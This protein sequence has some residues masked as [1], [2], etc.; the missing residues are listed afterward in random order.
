MVK[1]HARASRSADPAGD[2]PNH[3]QRA[4][5]TRRNTR[6]YYYANPRQRSA[7][8]HSRQHEDL[9]WPDPGAAGRAHARRADG[10]RPP[11]KRKSQALDQDAGTLLDRSQPHFA[12]AVTHYR[13][14]QACAQCQQNKKWA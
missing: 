7:C 6:L 9:D 14:G 12:A 8:S 4:N 11:G 5:L 3:R 10:D 2:E 1:G 13:R